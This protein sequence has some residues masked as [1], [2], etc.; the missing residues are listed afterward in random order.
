MKRIQLT[1]IT[2]FKKQC[3]C[4]T[5]QHQEIQACVE[6]KCECCNCFK[7]SGNL[8]I[9]PDNCSC[10]ASGHDDCCDVEDEHSLKKVSPLDRDLSSAI[11][12]VS[13]MDCPACAKSIERHLNRFPEVQSVEVN[14]SSGKMSIIHTLSTERIQQEVKKIGYQAIPDTLE[15]QET[16]QR[17][18]SHQSFLVNEL[19]V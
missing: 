2:H 3:T 12:Q 10:G 15:A 13:G 1:P 18:H 17:V 7:A 9:K 5:C 19:L 6:A 11:Y 8:A 16:V 14:F 4:S